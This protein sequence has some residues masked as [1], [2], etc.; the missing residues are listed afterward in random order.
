M[1]AKTH[2]QENVR[3]RDIMKNHVFKLEPTT[4]IEEAVTSFAEM[5][6]SGAPVADHHG[7]LV[8]MLSAFDIAQP[9]NMHREALAER[10][11]SFATADEAFDEEV[12]YDVEGPFLA[13][14]DARELQRGD[15]VADFMTPEVISIAPDATLR[16][17]CQLM[18]RE[19]IHRLPVMEQDRLVGIVSTLDIV[20]CVAESK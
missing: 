8:G 10:R 3:A 1:T 18:V 7:R 16:E 6:I 11:R 14:D 19:H 20:R 9:E 13:T 5:H 15:T 4:P 12:A 2:L 17:V